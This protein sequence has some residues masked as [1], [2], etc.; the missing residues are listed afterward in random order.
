[1]VR[2]QLEAVLDDLRPGATKSGM[3]A[4]ATVVRAVATVLRGR[5]VHPYV[6]DPVMVASSGDRLLEESAV[7]IIRQELLPLADLVTPNLDEAEILTGAPTRD[8]AAMEEAARALV[9][10][11]AR[12]ALVKGGHLAGGDPV[13]VLWNGET[14]RRF[15][16]RRI[17]TS[18]THGTG[19]TLSASI[20]ALLARGHSLE[21]AVEGA[22]DFVHAAIASAP[23]LGTGRG[24]VNHFAE[25]SGGEKQ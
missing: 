10:A 7:A 21:S 18:S 5:G 1:M 9:R 6:L 11:G 25:W 22:L 14:M 4:D 23:R 17:H 24:P 13:D 12:A 20:S 16:H 8:V 2:A 19:C 3:L 15:T